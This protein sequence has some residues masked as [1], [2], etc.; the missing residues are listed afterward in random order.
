MKRREALLSIL[1]STAASAP[2]LAP[3][4]A[5]AETT[6]SA[7]YIITS[8]LPYILIGLAH[9]AVVRVLGFLLMLI[10]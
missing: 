5:S 10:S 9:P 8:Y 4:K 6:G 1:L 7:Q 3:A 2:L